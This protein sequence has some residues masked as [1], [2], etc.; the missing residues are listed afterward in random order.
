MSNYT[1]T[2]K[3]AQAGAK[4]SDNKTSTAGHMWYSLSNSI[5]SVSFGFGPIK[6]GAPSGQ[7][8]LIGDDD[9]H[10]LETYYTGQISITK[11]QYDI[12]HDFGKKPEKYGFDKDKYNG[13]I[14]SCID[15]TYKALSVA[16]LNPTD[17]EGNLL[18]HDNSDNILNKIK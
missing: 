7:G 16:G 13:I 17:F 3:I 18:P 11:E 1:L 2:V 6:S 12:L 8:G 5:S 9:A 10:Y 14:N 4:L 15:F